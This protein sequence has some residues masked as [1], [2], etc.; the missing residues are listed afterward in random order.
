[1]QKGMEMIK[2]FFSAILIWV[3]LLTPFAVCAES[4]AVTAEERIGDYLADWMRDCSQARQDRAL[5]LVPL[6]VSISDEY[7]I[8][9][10]LVA[11]MV[12]AE[13]SWIPGA[14]GPKGELGLLQVHG[15]ALRGAERTT[16]GLLRAG[17]EWFAHCVDAAEGDP[18]R[19]IAVYM[20][21]KPEAKMFP[22]ARRR[23]NTYTKW[24]E[25]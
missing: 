10:V 3:A 1:M 8:D 11:V 14:V 19:A 21:G 17:V 18:Q 13:S 15:R 22:A 23:W 9:P 4:S 20:T 7:G 2:E 6:V 25:Q 24:R 5:A 16:E 12:S